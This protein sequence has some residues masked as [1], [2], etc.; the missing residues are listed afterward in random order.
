MSVAMLNAAFRAR[1]AELTALSSNE[2]RAECAHALQEYAERLGERVASQSQ[3]GR[4]LKA[5]QQQHEEAL[6]ELA[7][8]YRVQ[9]TSSKRVFELV[10][11]E[12]FV[13]SNGDMVIARD[14]L[15]V[16]RDLQEIGSVREAQFRNRYW[17]LAK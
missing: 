14:S 7:R 9:K 10:K 8:F 6:F 4:R 1:E 11:K 12:P 15:I 2:L 3:I 17:R 5:H 13:A 16:M